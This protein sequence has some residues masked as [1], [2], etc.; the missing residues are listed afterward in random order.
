[1]IVILTKV[2][3]VSVR[4]AEA[5]RH[6]AGF[7]ALATAVVHCKGFVLGVKESLWHW[8]ASAAHLL[9]LYFAAHTFYQ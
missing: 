2:L 9:C 8:K 1:M 7:M 4:A 3:F 6:T 5:G